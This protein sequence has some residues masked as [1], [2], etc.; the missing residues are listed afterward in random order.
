MT[1]LNQAKALVTGA[2]RGIGRAVT[3]A[4]LA[5]G[6]QVYGLFG[7]NRTAAEALIAE[8][9]NLGHSD[10]LRLQ[11]LDVSDYQA[12]AA[13]CASLEAEWD[14]LD[15]LVNSAGIRRDALVAM[16]REEDWRRVL[17][18]N[19]SGCFN[20]SKA[21]LPLMLKQKYGRI[22]FITSPM[23]HLGFPGQANYA[24]SK[25]GQIGL[26]KSL[27]K[28]VAKRRITV[29][30]ISPGFIDTEFLAG[31][32]EEQLKQYKKMVP[33]GRFGTT[34]EVAEA[35]LFLAGERA[36]YIN[37]AVLEITGGL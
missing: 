18:V 27:S 22:I 12:V 2:T 11:Q 29:N 8:T 7:G 20:T 37:G 25:A 28:E 6:A 5:E 15:I 26:M 17:D 34:E 1:P 24:A 33:A 30:C 19:L 4:L 13:C 36:G 32:G 16:L 31:L 35:V 23:G 10:R 3:L 14:T 9:E 21:A